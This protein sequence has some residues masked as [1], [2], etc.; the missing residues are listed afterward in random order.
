MK[1]L[2]VYPGYP[3]TFWSFRHALKFI[4]K[5]S[6]FPPLGL[7][8]VASMLPGEWEKKL[9]DMNTDTLTT[10]DIQWADYV[11]ISAMT[12]QRQSAK[13]V[14][15]R[16][17]EEGIPVVAGGPLFTTEH[18]KFEGV[19]HFVLNEA[20]LTLPAFL[21][22]LSNGCAGHMYTASGFPDISFTPVP[23]WEICDMSKYSSMCIQYSRG[24]PFDCEFCS[25]V[26]M[27]G[28]VPRTK[29]TEQLLAEMEAL[30]RTGWRSNVFIVDDNFIGNKKKLKESVLPALSAWLK[31]R[32]H[33]V[34]YTHLRAHET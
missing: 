33:P 14:I 12:I 6:T 11:F 10:R 21:D 5:K 9:V 3:D 16:C 19:N 17:N 24:C 32:R 4:S 23:A 18:D 25:I 7:L 27:N 26:A 20:E 31:Y 8:T 2:L 28:R 29:G 1:I 30:Y 22:D 13:E 34:S 15:A